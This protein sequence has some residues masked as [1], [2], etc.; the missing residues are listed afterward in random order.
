VDAQSF[1]I[2]SKTYPLLS[3]KGA[4][5]PQAV[6][7]AEDV[8]DFV[9]YAK[10]RGVRVVPEIDTPGHAYWYE[11]VP[12][13]FQKEEDVSSD[14]NVVLL[15]LSL[16]MTIVMVWDIQSLQRIAPALPAM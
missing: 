9:D 7:S 14:P 12:N 2:E 11:G 13:C 16:W 5:S 8:S 6:Y 3:Q 4:Y 15:L 10:K 1:P